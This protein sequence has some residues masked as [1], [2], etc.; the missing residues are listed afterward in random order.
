V[1]KSGEPFLKV[2]DNLGLKSSLDQ[3]FKVQAKLKNNSKR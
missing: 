1:I 2:E 3:P